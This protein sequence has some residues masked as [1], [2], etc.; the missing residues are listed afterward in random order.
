[1]SVYAQTTCQIIIGLA[2]RLIGLSFELLSRTSRASLSPP[3][4]SLDISSQICSQA[5]TLVLEHADFP[6]IILTRER[7]HDNAAQA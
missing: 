7:P 5:G 2:Y 3:Q 6:R 1:M 4:L